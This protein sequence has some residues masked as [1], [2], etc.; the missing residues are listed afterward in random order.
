MNRR[1]ALPLPVVLA[2][3]VL[4]GGLAGCDIRFDSREATGDEVT[5]T[6]DVTAVT[7]VELRTSGILN[8]AVGDEPGLSVTGRADVLEDL[9]TRVEGDTLV[10]DLDDAWRNIG[11]LEVNLVVPELSAVLLSGSGG[12]YGELGADDAVSLEIDG[13][14]D[15]G[16]SELAADDVRLAIHGSGDIRV[17]NVTT[18]MLDVVVDGSGDVEVGGDTDHVRI[19][20]PGSGTVDAAELTARTGE[21]TI[22]G[23]GETTVAVSDALDASIEGSG[24]ITYLGD[25]EVTQD[26]DGSGDVSQG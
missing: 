15:I 17:E 25:P 22:D 12:V 8:L 1:R 24:D 4:A 3:A 10:I 7:A 18:T 6:R 2:A 11:Y 20:I 23:S 14:G 16:M 19:A 13:S 5:E 9:E 21:V 26:I